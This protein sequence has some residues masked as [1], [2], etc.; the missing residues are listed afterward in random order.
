[1]LKG[2]L[3]NGFQPPTIWIN[4]KGSEIIPPIVLPHSRCPI[5]S[6]PKLDC[7]RMKIDDSLSGRRIEGDV[8]PRSRGGG[9][10]VLEDVKKLMLFVRAV[11]K[12]SDF[13]GGWVGNRSAVVH[14][15]EAERRQNRRVKGP[16]DNVVTHPD[17]D[18]T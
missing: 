12:C 10:L 4:D 6:A 14:E 16:G 15:S 7:F 17:R 9:V 3:A 8:E 2:N 5:V 18:V 13:A 11:P 1:M